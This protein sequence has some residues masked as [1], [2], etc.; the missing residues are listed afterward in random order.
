MPADAAFCTLLS[1]ACP[2]LRLPFILGLYMPNVLVLVLVTLLLLPSIAPDPLSSPGAKGGNKHRPA[3]KCAIAQSWPWYHWALPSY[4]CVAWAIVPERP[5]CVP[6]TLVSSQHTSIRQGQRK[7][8]QIIVCRLPPTSLSVPFSLFLVRNIDDL[9]P[10]RPSRPPR[11]EHGER[12]G[13]HL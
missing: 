8:S 1:A 7:A 10:K 3:T 13:A 6:K 4:R 12:R 11:R 5:C 9:V 2:A